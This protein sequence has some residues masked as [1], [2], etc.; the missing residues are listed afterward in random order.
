[1]QV[2]PDHEVAI[3]GGGT[4]GLGIGDALRRAGFTDFV[5]FER[6]GD[7]GGTWRDNTY[8]GVAVDI[9]GFAYQFSHYCNPHWSRV[10]PPGAEI[11]AYLDRFCDEMGLRP[12]LRLNTDVR[13]RTWDEDQ[14]LWRLELHDGST[15]TARWCVGAIGV[16]CEPAPVQFAGFEDFQG[17]VL[18]SQEWDHDYDF[19][20]KRVACIGTGASGL[21]IIPQIARQVSHLD[22]YQ[23]TPIWVAVKK[24]PAIPPRLQ[25]LMERS[26][27]ARK[28]MYKLFAIPVEFFVIRL[29]TRYMDTPWALTATRELVRRHHQRAIPDPEMFEKLTPTYEFACKRP[30][31]S[32]EYLP[33]LQADH[34]EVVTTPIE[35]F[36]AEGIR[37]VDG[38]VRPIDA[39]VLATGFID[40]YDPRLYRERPVRGRDGFD[41]A[42]HWESER[43]SAYQGLCHPKLPNYF[44]VFGPYAGIA[45]TFHP[46]VEAAGDV[47]VRLIREANRR[48]ATA[49]EVT[50][51]AHRAWH[52]EM[53]R[54][55][56]GA[57]W[58]HAPCESSRTYF[59]ATH[60]DVLLLRPTSSKVAFRSARTFPFDDFTFETA[61]VREVAAVS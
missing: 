2:K 51:A 42:E 37:T 27:L 41:L 19:A 46:L 15:V 6:K 48:G 39:V 34:V 49:T 3:V 61:P 18:R 47:I 5:I 7:I 52:R 35:R 45:G 38:E 57:L 31:F 40:A 59:Y 36:V 58:Y 30:S 1:V 8:P 24:D 22:V 29:M 16:Y 11:K 53:L 50:Q 25:R 60:G 54:G 23:R 17:K 9:P 12:H 44:H 4:A 33:T 56:Q 20:G 14:H 43:L 13:S 26:P 55:M 28:A 32:N 21:Q 10:Y